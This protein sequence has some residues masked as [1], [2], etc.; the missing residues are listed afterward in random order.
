LDG[1]EQARSEA[2]IDWNA[3]AEDFAP[4]GSLRDVYVL[5]ANAEDW[6]LVLKALGASSASVRYSVDGVE[7]PGPPSAQAAFAI[8]S[9][10]S[11]S[12]RVAVGGIEFACHFFTTD[13]I[14]FDFLPSEVNGPD[15]LESLLEFVRSLGRTTTM[16]L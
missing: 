5:E 16:S 8:H 1:P 10:A 14:E 4:D 12:L 11:P 3:V 7:Q 2:L 6:E 9:V 15:R 13:E